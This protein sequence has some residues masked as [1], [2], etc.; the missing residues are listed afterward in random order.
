MIRIALFCALILSL[1]WPALA[2]EAK[3]IGVTDGDSITVLMPDNK[4]VKVRL[5]GIDCPEMRQ[6]FGRVAK[7]AT[8]ALAAGKTVDVEVVETDRYGRSV[9]L[10][11]LPDGQ[12]LSRQLLREGMAWVYTQYC[13]R[14][15]CDAWRG[16]EFVAR[17]AGRGL[18]RDP[19]AMPPWEWRKLKR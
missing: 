18:W 17:D 19:Q 1:A 6:P 12:N 15:E 2:Y 5:Y 10:V 13:K 9:A 11:T 14:P 16:V 7:R 4:E 3:V 8:A